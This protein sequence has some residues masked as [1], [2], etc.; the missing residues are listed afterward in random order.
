[1]RTVRLRNQRRDLGRKRTSGSRTSSRQKPGRL[2]IWPPLETGDVLIAADGFRYELHGEFVGTARK[3][4][5]KALGIRP[6]VLI[7]RFVCERCGKDA[8]LKCVASRKPSTKICGGC[9][10]AGRPASQA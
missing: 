6:R 10:R 7:W 4:V 3:P 5:A 8:R 9:R 2:F 1:M